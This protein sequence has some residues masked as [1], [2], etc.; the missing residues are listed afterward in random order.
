[1]RDLDA[2]R[3]RAPAA[4]EARR[5][6]GRA[7]CVLVIDS[8]P[9]V[10]ELMQRLGTRARIRRRDRDERG[11]GTAPRVR[12]AAGA[13]H[14]RRGAARHGR[15]EAPRDS[16]AP[17]RTLGGTP[18]VVVSVDRRPQPRTR[19]RRRRLFRQAHRPRARWPP[20]W[21]AAGRGGGVRRLPWPRILIVEDNEL[22]RDMLSRRLEKRG[23]EVAIAGDGEEGVAKAAAEGPG[24]DPHGPRP[25]RPRRLGGD[26]SGSRPSGTPRASRSSGFP[27]TRWPRTRRRRGGAGCDDFDTKPVELPRLLGK[28]EALL[29]RAPRP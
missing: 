11:R 4:G 9:A 12:E 8:D 25:A 26:A 5:R 6:S 1:M 29:R 24:P 20:S 17:T 23:Y 18:I 10:G 3:R 27:P 22:S 13:H 14:A 21:R 16:D 2:R 19:A 7:R 28:I 15:L